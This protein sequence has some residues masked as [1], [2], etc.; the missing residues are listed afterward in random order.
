MATR[1]KEIVKSILK[2]RI[3]IKGNLEKSEGWLKIGNVKFNKDKCEVLP[4]GSR[5]QILK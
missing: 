3:E 2:N 1:N 5:A 4:R